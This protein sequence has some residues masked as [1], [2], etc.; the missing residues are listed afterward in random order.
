M[1]K[2]WYDDREPFTSSDGPPELAPK[3]GVQCV[4]VSDRDHGWYFCRSN[5]FYI[6]AEYDGTMGWQGV[7]YFGL[8]D[9]LQA[10]GSKVVLFGRTIGNVEYRQL[11]NRATNDPELPQKTAYH[12]EERHG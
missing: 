7:D 12:A 2:V 4:V 5:D 11:L 8:W 10:P 9:Y 3:R 6:W 1:W